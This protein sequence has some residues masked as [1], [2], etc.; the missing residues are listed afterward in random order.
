MTIDEA[1]RQVD[2]W[3]KTYGVRYFSELT[4][5]AILTEEVGEVARIMARSYGDQST[6]P[7]EK[8]NLADELADVMWVLICIANQTGKDLTE[9]FRRNLE[10]KTA[11]DKERHV[12]NPKLK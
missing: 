4:N 11:R 5:M 3:I 7:G 10:K 9:A 1:Q 6:K 12:N 8:T 2:E